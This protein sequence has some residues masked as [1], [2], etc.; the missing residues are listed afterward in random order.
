MQY[1]D[2]YKVLGVDRG[3]PQEE[4]SRAYKKAARKFHPDLNKAPDA[5]DRFKEVNEA[6]DVLK[7][8]ETRKRYDTLG[9]NWKHGSDFSPPPG[10]GNGA[11]WEVHS[12]P[13]AAGFSDFFDQVFGGGRPH[14]RGGAG[15]G[16]GGIN[17]E[18]LLGGRG[19]MGGTG[20]DPFA[21]SGPRRPARGRDIETA[22]ALTLEDIYRAEKIKVRLNGPEGPRSYDV[23]VPRGVRQGERV[24]LAGQG[25]PGANG[26]PG[27]LYLRVDFARHDRFRVE[28]DHLVV[29]VPVSCWDAALG[30]S[31]PVPTL[32]GEVQMTLPP[33]LSSGQ[34]LRLK[35]KGLPRKDGTHGDLRAELKVTVPQTLT[36]TQQRLFAE[37]R[38]HSSALGAQ[39]KTVV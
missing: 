21:P 7:D 23:K 11:Q 4:I 24:R 27:D 34:R 13:G 28:G 39:G 17:L 3:A 1:V 6:H 26:K 30:G 29:T 20:R 9:A 31:I 36:S 18:D 16:V 22:L 12:S 32:D 8:P 15:P 2:Y 19:G 38:D 37:L 35:G 33:G 10:W 5:E 14:A 25:L